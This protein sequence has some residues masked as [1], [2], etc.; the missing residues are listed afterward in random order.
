MFKG[1][2]AVSVWVSKYKYVLYTHICDKLVDSL[3]FELSYIELSSQPINYLLNNW[4]MQL[5][6]FGY[7]LSSVMKCWWVGFSIILYLLE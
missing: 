1:T 4:L 5:F 7:N 6:D 2:L 3:S